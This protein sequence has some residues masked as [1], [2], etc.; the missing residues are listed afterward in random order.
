MAKKKKNVTQ[1]KRQAEKPA[2]LDEKPQ[3]KKTVYVARTPD[4]SGAKPTW[5]DEQGTYRNSTME[6]RSSSI[7]IT[8]P[9][10]EVKNKVIETLHYFKEAGFDKGYIKSVSEEEN[11][12]I[13]VSLDSKN[14]QDTYD[15]LLESI[16]GHFGLIEQLY[17]RVQ[18]GEELK[19]LSISNRAAFSEA[20]KEK[21]RYSF[22]ALQRTNMPEDYF[23]YA[24]I[25][26]Y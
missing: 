24:E 9:V 12:K 10:E 21:E 11:L 14:A 1:V 4:R 13:A 17:V 25:Q 20:R 3:I 23:D 6:S 7:S 26:V 16:E 15:W 8:E 22:K 2:F 18:K 5:L 19:T